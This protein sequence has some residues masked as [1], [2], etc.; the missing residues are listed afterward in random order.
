MEAAIV[1][2]ILG[3]LLIVWEY[4]SATDPDPKDKLKKRKPLALPD[5]VRLRG[6]VF[7]TF[8]L[9]GGVWWATWFFD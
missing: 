2:V 8:A 9:A 6:L 3:F 5:K 4:R 1:V 7:V